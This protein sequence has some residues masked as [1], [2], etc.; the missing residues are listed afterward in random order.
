MKKTYFM[1]KLIIALITCLSLALISGS[2]SRTTIL[3]KGE[4]ND[5]PY[6]TYIVGLEGH[7]NESPLAYEAIQVL[8]PNLVNPQDIVIVSQKLYIAEKGNDNQADGYILVYD[9]NNKTY[10]KIGEGLIA[11]ASGVAIG[12]SGEVYAVDNEKRVVLK[13]ASDGTLLK[14]YARPTEALFGESSLFMPTKV[15]VDRRG[16]IYITS[17]GNANGIIQLN[18]DGEF[19]GYFGPNTINLTLSLL[20]KRLMLPKEDRD[21]YASLSPRVTTN[22]AIDNKNIVYTV[23]EGEGGVSIKKFNVNGTN[24][25]NKTGFFSTTY[26]D[27]TVDEQG[28]IYTIDRSDRGTIQVMDETGSLLFTFGSTK[29]ASMTL[30]EF[31]KA[32]GIAV[33]ESGNIW[34]LDNIGKNIQVFR[35]TEFAE[36]VFKAI[37]AYNEGRYDEAILYYNEILSKNASFVN[38]YIGLGKIAQRNEDYELASSYFKIAN[39]KSGYSEVYWEQRDNWLGKN[40]VWIVILIAV[41]VLCRIFRV[42]RRLSKFMPP[43][44]IQFKKNLQEKRFVQELSYIGKVLRKPDYVFYDVKYYLSIRKRTSLIFLSI[45]ILINIFGTFILR[46]YLFRTTNL[47]NVNFTMEILKWILIIGIFAFANFLISTL[48]NGEGFFRDIFIGTVISFAPVLI[49]KLPIDLLSNFLT[50]NEAYLFHILNL[51][52][53]GWSILNIILML[54]EIHNFT[55]KELIINILLTAV[56]IIV[57]ILLALVIYI[58]ANQLIQFIVNLF[59]EGAMR[60]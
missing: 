5:D 47:Q 21:T 58:L 50:F 18:D 25:L 41:L 1:K 14:T 23:I 56:A 8:N 51:F 35:K 48:Q 11:G 26:Q 44:V 37:K 17:T 12:A 32:V 33:D 4:L 31:D 53:W 49:F 38:A 6:E 28:F 29:T 27:L 52:M 13:F 16:N 42:F 40:L 45:F 24:I 46:G 34:V 9:I 15:A 30:G 19:V 2:I 3:A 7:L 43:K 39:Y 55:I 59:K 57:L 60:T 54:K 20:L 10:T 36:T 22:L